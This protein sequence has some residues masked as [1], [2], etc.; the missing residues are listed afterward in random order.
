MKNWRLSAL[1]RSIVLWVQ[2]ATKEKLLYW[3]FYWLLYCSSPGHSEILNTQ[4]VETKLALPIL[5]TDGT[6]LNHF[7]CL[8]ANSNFR[9]GVACFKGLSQR[10]LWL[11][12]KFRNFDLFATGDYPILL[13]V[14]NI[15]F[16]DIHYSGSSQYYSIRWTCGGN[17]ELASW[18]TVVKSDKK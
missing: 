14:S 7:Y 16:V 12:K 10:Q 4:Y 13:W 18:N 11:I 15:T 2:W 17:A 3:H 5:T 8:L 1:K 6:I 9:K